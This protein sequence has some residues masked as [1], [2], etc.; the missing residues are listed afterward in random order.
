M[1]QYQISRDGA[2]R[3]AAMSRLAL[4]LALN[5]RGV[6]RVLLPILL[7]ALAALGVYWLSM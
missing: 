7:A 1:G 2:E 3:T 4:W 5:G 6:E